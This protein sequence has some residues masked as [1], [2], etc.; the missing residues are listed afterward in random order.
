MTGG[1]RRGSAYDPHATHWLIQLADMNARRTA[2]ATRATHWLIQRSGMNA[3]RAAV[4]TRRPCHPAH[5]PQTRARTTASRTHCS[6]AITPPRPR[7]VFSLQDT[8][9]CVSGVIIVFPVS[10]ALPGAVFVGLLHAHATHAFWMSVRVVSLF[11][12]CQHWTTGPSPPS[13]PP[14]SLSNRKSDDKSSFTPRRSPRARAAKFVQVGPFLSI[15]KS[16]GQSL[17]ILKREAPF[18]YWTIGRLSRKFF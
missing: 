10:S 13:A 14:P 4:A 8:T 3:R 9:E 5:S 2:M 1:D 6:H 17:P 11:F 16:P 12:S 15:T 18:P 7:P